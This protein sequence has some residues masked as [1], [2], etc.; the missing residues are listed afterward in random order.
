MPRVSSTRNTVSIAFQQRTYSRLS[1]IFFFVVFVDRQ[2]SELSAFRD[3]LRK[4]TRMQF[5]NTDELK[6]VN[7]RIREAEEKL[8]AVRQKQFG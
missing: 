4:E 7:Q 8:S 3:D 2:L 5:E 6:R 1:I